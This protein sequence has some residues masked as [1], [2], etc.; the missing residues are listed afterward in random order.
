MQLGEMHMAQGKVVASA[1]DRKGAGN[2]EEPRAPA[3]GPVDQRDKNALR[4]H[5]ELL[6]RASVMLWRAPS[7]PGYG[8]HLI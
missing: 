3:L 7:R 5:K 8:R 6:S 2:V 1:G 4:A